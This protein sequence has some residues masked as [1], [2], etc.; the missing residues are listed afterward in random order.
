MQKLTNRSEF[1]C[2]NTLIG[3]MLMLI[4]VLVESHIRVAFAF[5]EGTE[6]LTLIKNNKEV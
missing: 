3:L 4:G 1:K 6:D 2:E 5:Y